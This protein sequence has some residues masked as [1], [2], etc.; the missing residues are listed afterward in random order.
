MTHKINIIWFWKI[1]QRAE[2]CSSSSGHKKM[3][4]IA[5]DIKMIILIKTTFLSAVHPLLLGTD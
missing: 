5:D 2:N 4:P 3:V 1:K